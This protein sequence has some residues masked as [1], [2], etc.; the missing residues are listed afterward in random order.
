VSPKK[1]VKFWFPEWVLSLH[2]TNVFLTF[3]I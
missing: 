2:L 3:R 1:S